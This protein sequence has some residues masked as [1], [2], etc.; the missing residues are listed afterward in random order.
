MTL[1][2]TWMKAGSDAANSAF[3]LTHG[4]PLPPATWTQQWQQEPVRN[5]QKKVT[6]PSMSEEPIRGTAT[7]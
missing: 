7:R 4:T 2:T 1:W 5:V 6:I 3:G